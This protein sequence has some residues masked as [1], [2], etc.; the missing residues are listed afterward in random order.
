M[1]KI[2]FNPRTDYKINA[3]YSSNGLYKTALNMICLDGKEMEGG[4][5]I[6]QNDFD[7]EYDDDYDGEPVYLRPVYTVIRIPGCFFPAANEINKLPIDNSLKNFTY[8]LHQDVA[9]AKYY[10]INYFL[11]KL[12]G[13]LT[14]RL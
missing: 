13:H 1:Y 5:A 10:L 6:M 12:G 8:S 9:E 2:T 14:P 7:D 11:G 4:W 3:M